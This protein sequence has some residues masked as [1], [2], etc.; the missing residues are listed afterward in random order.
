MQCLNEKSPDHTMMHPCRSHG[1]LHVWLSSVSIGLVSFATL[2]QMRLRSTDLGC[3]LLGPWNNP[4][5]PV[6]SVVRP[7]SVQLCHVS[8]LIEFPSIMSPLGALRAALL[9]AV[10]AC[11]LSLYTFISPLGA[12]RLYGLDLESS[13]SASSTPE[14]LAVRFAPV[15]GGRNF[16]LGLAILTFHWQRM[17]RAI[18]TVLTCC[19]VEGSVIRWLQGCGER[20]R[21]LGVMLLGL[22]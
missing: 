20:R 11:L 22:S 15:F 7:I 8:F 16:A 1:M 13:V 18:G 10:Y 21:R 19:M 3:N 4:N 5:S 12:A 2:T 14:N 9:L 6:V 17:P